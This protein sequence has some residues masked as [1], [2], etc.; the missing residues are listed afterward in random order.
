MQAHHTQHDADVQG[1]DWSA[2]WIPGSQER[3][4]SRQAYTGCLG[5]KRLPYPLPEFQHLAGCG[6]VLHKL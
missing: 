5:F 4:E 1:V 2:Y 6:L 3:P